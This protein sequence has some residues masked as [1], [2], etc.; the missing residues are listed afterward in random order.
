[1][2]EYTKQWIQ[3][4]ISWMFLIAIFMGIAGIV[5][6]LYSVSEIH[7]NQPIS[8]IPESHTLIKISTPENATKVATGV[9]RLS[10]GSLM[11]CMDSTH[12]EIFDM[13]QFKRTP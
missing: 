10:N 8:N 3:F 12:C 2:K 11:G 4:L 5:L 1:M 9:Y 13:E 6:S 7:A